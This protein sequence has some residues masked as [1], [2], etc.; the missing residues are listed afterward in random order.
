MIN[1]I[2]VL[3]NGHGGVIDGVYQTKGKRS[4]DWE[5]GVLYEGAFNRWIVNGVI[6]RLD[7][8]NKPYFHVSPELEDIS[9]SARV[10]RANKI[11][12]KNG[13]NTYLLSIH[14]NAGGG[15][16]WEI[17]TSPGQTSSDKIAEEFAK[18]FKNDLPIKGRMDMSDGDMDKEAKFYVLTKTIGPAILVECGFMDNKEDY[19]KL[20]DKCFREKV[21]NSIV[22]TILKLY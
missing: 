5:Q 21:I 2:P 15:T 17:F 13:K 3:D 11:Y 9:L 20:W 19:K 10:E 7:K 12:S 22:D 6:E 14:A 18:G 8:L 4:P 1:M 16:G